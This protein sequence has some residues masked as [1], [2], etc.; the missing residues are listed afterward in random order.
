MFD[1]LRAG[2]CLIL[3][4]AA[5]ELALANWLGTQT[6]ASYFR[7]STIFSASLLSMFPLILWLSAVSLSVVWRRVDRPSLKIYRA[8]RANRNWLAR[9]ML[10]SFLAVPLGRAVT[11]VKVAIPS[12]RPFYADPRLIDLDLLI[13]R[14][15]PW[16][17][18]HRWIGPMAT[19]AIDRAYALWF[20]MMMLFI[21]WAA[22]TRRADM[23]VRMLL[24]LFLTWILL[25]NILAI[26]FSSVGPCFYQH[27]Y[28][29]PRFAELMEI[30]QGYDARYGLKSIMAMRYLMDS[31]GTLKLGSGISAMP[32]IHVGVS[33]L[34]VL[35]CRSHFKRRWGTWLAAAY[36]AVIY[37]G[38]IHLGW[39]YAVDGLVSIVLVALIWAGC[40][41][42]VAWLERCERSG[43]QFQAI[44]RRIVQRGQ[45]VIG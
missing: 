11:E 31:F 43:K 38:S 37:V 19:V 42:F 9:G 6:L 13:F 7:I 34:F 16:Q 17:L 29:N 15:D 40:G 32:S 18:T 20:V 44:G 24:A 36:A 5:G 25:G 41:V 2:Y 39:H 1:R 12:I 27:F 8:F 14:T 35:A 45:G 23:Q 4:L 26:T 33:F 22:F 30:Q 28:G 3:I 21:G 10:F